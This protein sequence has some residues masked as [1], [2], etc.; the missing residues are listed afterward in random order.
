MPADAGHSRLGRMLSAVHGEGTGRQHAELHASGLDWTSPP[1]RLVSRRQPVPGDEHGDAD[2]SARL[3]RPADDPRRLWAG[4]DGT[5]IQRPHLHGWRPG[6]R[7]R[8]GRQVGD[9][10]ADQCRERFDRDVRDARADAGAGKML[11]HRQRRRRH[12]PRRPGAAGARAAAARRCRDHQHQCQSG[13]RGTHHRRNVRRYAWRHR[14]GAT[15]RGRQ[16]G[17]EYSTPARWRR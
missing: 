12:V 4:P 2:A 10:V 1:Y 3:H 15:V 6:R 13:Q 9:A 14:Q 7:P 16:A 17:E 11:R 8:R 5:A